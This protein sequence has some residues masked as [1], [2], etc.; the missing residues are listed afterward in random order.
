LIVVRGRDDSSNYFSTMCQNKK[1]NL[2]QEE[3]SQC[4]GCWRFPRCGEKQK[5][6]GRYFLILLYFVIVSASILYTSMSSNDPLIRQM[7]PNTAYIFRW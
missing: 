4:N 1:A 5:V 7:W 2:N 6:E 3:V